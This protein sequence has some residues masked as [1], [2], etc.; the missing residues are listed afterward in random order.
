MTA[1]GS[2]ATTMGAE[3]GPHCRA[4]LRGGRRGQG[5]EGVQ[6]ETS[7]HGECT[8]SSPVT[9]LI[10]EF[11]SNLLSL[12]TTCSPQEPQNHHLLAV[13]KRFLQHLLRYQK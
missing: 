10:P 12:M 11:V 3:G 4:G 7:W 2:S 1:V 5:C 6:R 9:L 8:L 13:F